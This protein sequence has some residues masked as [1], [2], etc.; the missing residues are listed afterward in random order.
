MGEGLFPVPDDADPWARMLGAACEGWR[1]ATA[2]ELGVPVLS[3]DE[4]GNTDDRILALEEDL[5]ALAAR[6]AA[7][8]VRHASEL[9]A[10]ADKIEEL[11]PTSAFEPVAGSPRA[12]LLRLAA[13]LRDLAGKP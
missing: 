2:V 13:G 11:L 9:E 10:I 8:Q 12:E 7:V 4:W 5:D 1:A 6:A 3:A